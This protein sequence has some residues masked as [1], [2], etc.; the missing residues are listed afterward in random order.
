MN[1]DCHIDTFKEFLFSEK[2]LSQNSINNY[3][4]DLN[5]FLIF[6]IKHESINDNVQKYI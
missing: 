3:L 6:F 5:Q 1:L 4:V 2:N